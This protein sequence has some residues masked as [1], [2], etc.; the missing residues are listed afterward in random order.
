[1]FFLNSSHNKENNDYHVEND[2]DSFFFS[3]VSSQGE[4]S[5][6][7]F[8][9]SEL[10]DN[11]YQIDDNEL[12]FNEVHASSRVQHQKNPKKNMG[13]R[14]IPEDLRPLYSKVKSCIRHLDNHPIRIA[15]MHCIEVHKQE[16]KSKR[17]KL[18]CVL[19]NKD[20][21]PVDYFLFHRGSQCPC[22]K[23]QDQF[24]LISLLQPL[25]TPND[26]FLEQL[27]IVAA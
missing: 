14:D 25:P 3:S 13:E 12:H 1:M 5:N 18:K 15:D 6:N 7:S 21:R 8:S 11:D 17:W 4:I 27:A 23:I 24:S 2:N 19:C 10:S 20:F 9:N 26:S 16:K 22:F